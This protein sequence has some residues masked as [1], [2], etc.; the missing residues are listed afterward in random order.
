MDVRFRGLPGELVRRAR[1][2]AGDR[3]QAVLIGLLRA[4]VDGVIDPLRP[5]SSSR[6]ASGQAQA[7]AALLGARGGAATA[8][9]R[10][11]AERSRAATHAVESRWSKT[12]AESEG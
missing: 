4:Y 6:A 11:P 5:A 10:S 1:A 2:K 12:R 8:V 9:A 3:L 7:A